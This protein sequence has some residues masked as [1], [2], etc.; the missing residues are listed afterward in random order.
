MKN[1]L[2]IVIGLFLTQQGLAFQRYQCDDGT[3]LQYA[4]YDLPP[5]GQVIS[6]TAQGA[7]FD[8][9]ISHKGSKKIFASVLGAFRGSYDTRTEIELLS[10]KDVRVSFSAPGKDTVDYYVCGYNTDV[11]NK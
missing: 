7:Q 10:N 8:L 1:F 6:F 11:F 4:Y 3:S 5:Y 2:I 9:Q